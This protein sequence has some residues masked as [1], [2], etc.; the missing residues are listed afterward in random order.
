MKMKTLLAVG[1]A[2]VAHLH[3]S[4]S[5]PIALYV[6]EGAGKRISIYHLDASTGDLTHFGAADLPGSPGS[7]AVSRDRRHLYAS[8][9][10]GKQFATL[11][12]DA[13]TG[14]LGSP[15]LADA[16]FNA[17]Y[18]HVDRTGRW[19]LAAAYGEGVA[20]VSEI[21]DGI[22]QGPPVVTLETGKKAHSIQTDPTNRFAFVPHVGE[23]NKV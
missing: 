18:V 23:L 12:V 10:S 4:F 22:V 8:I 2:L 5:A 21:K 16:G 19:L 17:A 14:A 3:A 13:K 9:R 6:S 1:F 20:G 7:L 15:V 11:P